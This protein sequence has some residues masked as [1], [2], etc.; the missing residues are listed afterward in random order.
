MLDVSDPTGDDNGPG[1]YQYP[2]STDFTAGSFDLTHFAV[3]QDGT[4]VYIQTTLRDAGP[5]VRVNFFG[6]QLLDIYVRT[7]ARR[8][9]RP[10]PRIPAT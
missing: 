5:H 10:P 4:N 8:R 7:R 1:T 3:S 6:A 2:T 9:R